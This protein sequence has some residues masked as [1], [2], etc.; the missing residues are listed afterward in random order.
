VGKPKISADEF[1][2]NNNIKRTHKKNHNYD[3]IIENTP[4]N[5]TPKGSIYFI[6]HNRTG[7]IYIGQT[8]RTVETRI[9]EHVENSTNPYSNSYNSR[10]CKA[11]REEGIANFGYGTLETGINYDLLDS[12]EQYYIKQHNAFDW[13]NGYNSTPGGRANDKIYAEMYKDSNYVNK[14]KVYSHTVND[15]DIGNEMQK[16]IDKHLP[17]NCTVDDLDSKQ[18]Q[19]LAARVFNELGILDNYD[20]DTKR[21][22]METIAPDYP[23]SSNPNLIEDVTVD[24]DNT[25]IYVCYAILIMFIILIIFYFL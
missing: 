14:S 18:K 21:K 5:N 22:L 1:L 11:L 9:D 19:K 10:L 17:Y 24:D 16:L 6:Q 15:S 3:R 12:K 2:R 4:R 13:N 23:Y 8:T 7:K 20:P 25:G